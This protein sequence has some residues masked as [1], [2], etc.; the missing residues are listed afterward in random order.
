[1]VSLTA[2]IL[3]GGV[4]L[5][6]IAGGG[7]LISPALGQARTDLDK[8]KGFTT[9]QVANIKATLTRNKDNMI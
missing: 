4:A 2:I 5:F 1:M 9:D 8:A 7:S 6:L 3:I